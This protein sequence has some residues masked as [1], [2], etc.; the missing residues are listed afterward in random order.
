MHDAVPRRDAGAVQFCRRAQDRATK[1]LAYIA[2]VIVNGHPEVR[3]SRSRCQSSHDRPADACR[4]P[5]PHIRQ[6]AAE[7]HARQASANWGRTKFATWVREQKRLLVTDTTMRDAHQSLL[8]TRMRTYDMLAIATAYAPHAR[9]T[10]LAGDVGRGDV[11][12]VDAVPQGVAVGAARPTCA[13]RSRT[14]SSRCCCGPPTPS[15]TPT[16][17]TTSSTSSSSESAEAG[18]DLFRIFDAINWLPNLKLGDRGGAAR[19]TRICEAAICYTG[20]ILDPKRDKYTLNVLRRISPRSW[21][22]SARTSSPSRTWPGCCKPYAA[23][24]AGQ[25]AAARSRHADPLPHARLGRRADR[26]VPAWPPEEGVDIVDCAFAPLAGVTSQPNLNA[27]VEALRF[28]DRDT[29][30]DFDPLQE[31]ADLLGRR[32][33]VLLPVRDGPGRQFGRGLSARDARRAVHE[34]V[35]AGPVARASASAGTKSAGCTPTVNQLFGDIV[36]VTPTSKVVGDMALFMVA[37]NLTPEQVLDPKRELAFPESVVEF[38]EGKLGQP[39]GGFPTELQARVLRGRKPLTDRP[40][41]L[42]A[43]GRLRQGRAQ[44]TRSQ[45]GP[46]ADRPGRDLVPALPEGVPRLRR[47]S[48]AVLRHQRAADAGLLLRHGDGRGDQHRHRAGQDADLKFLTV[49]EPH[50]DG[51]RLVFFELNGQPREVLVDGSVARCG[52]VRRCGRKP[53]PATRSTSRRRCR[54]RWSASRSAMG[55]EVAAGQKLLDARSDEDGDDALRRTTP[56]RSPKC[57]S[58]PARRSRAAIW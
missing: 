45:A 33:A 37:N 26:V 21:R 56:A 2:D 43:A 1:L 17:P 48:D 23:Q 38:F 18:I 20:D 54:G 6:R 53:S 46:H 47:S 35:S 11:R 19:P 30:L 44:G 12:H 57:W 34:P 41:A 39:P 10:V 36:K 8:A 16:T 25:G 27:L 50:P 15:A 13:S 5:T 31:T 40:G 49:G 55:E 51:R 52:T 22:S 9:R 3:G 14:S 42:L 4:H 58:G 29:G 24:E 28:T 7:G 32:P